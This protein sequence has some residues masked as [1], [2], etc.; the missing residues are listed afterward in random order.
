MLFYYLKKAKRLQKKVD[1]LK[2]DNDSLNFITDK[3]KQRNEI[4]TKNAI[5]NNDDDRI[6]RMRDKD[7]LRNKD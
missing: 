2:S 6:K 7:Q 4:E 1:K 5:N 3:E